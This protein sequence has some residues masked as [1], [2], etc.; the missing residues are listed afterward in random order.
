[1]E[2]HTEGVPVQAAF[3]PAQR[4][5]PSTRRPEKGRFS[6]GRVQNPGIL[7]T[8]DCPVGQ[9]VGDLWRGKEGTALLAEG[10]TVAGSDHGQIVW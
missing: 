9:V 6:A 10:E 5:Q 7:V 3:V 1:M 2:I 4:P 8:T